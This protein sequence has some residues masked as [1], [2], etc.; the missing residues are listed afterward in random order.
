[1]RNTRDY[2]ESKTIKTKKEKSHY[3]LFF[4]L[5]GEDSLSLLNLI[6]C[7]RT[8]I[9]GWVRVANDVRAV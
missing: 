5:F 7:N 4:Y 8:I 3:Y 2:K 9:Y 1:M 6:R